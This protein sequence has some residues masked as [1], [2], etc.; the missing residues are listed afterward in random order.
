MAIEPER[1]RR[2]P[3]VHRDRRG[4]GMR[5]PLM[6]AQLPG[7]RTRAEAFDQAVL[8]AV[9]DLEDRWP[10]QLAAIEF[11][12][13]EVPPLPSGPV[14]PSSDAVVDGGVPLSRFLPPGVDARGRPTKAR[15]VVYRRPVE[16]RSRHAADVGDLIIDVLE[17][18]ISAVLGNGTGQ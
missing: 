10:G 3:L 16:V 1:E 7:F 8:E 6:P 17:E 2:P 9:A 12:V 15:I 11:A 18:Q 13:D 5:M 14:L 4:R